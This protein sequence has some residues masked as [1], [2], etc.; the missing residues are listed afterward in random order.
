LQC[1]GQTRVY[2]KYHAQKGS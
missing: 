2:P 1:E